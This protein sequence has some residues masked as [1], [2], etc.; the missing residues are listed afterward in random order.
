[1]RSDQGLRQR[2]DR[3]ENGVVGVSSYMFWDYIWR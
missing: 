1:M 2:N 3:E